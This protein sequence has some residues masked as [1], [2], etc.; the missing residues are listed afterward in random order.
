MPNPRQ[1]AVKALVSVD[2]E[3]GYSNIVLDRLL[4]ESGPS[5]ADSALASAL[6]YGVLDRKVTLD[7]CLQPY[8]SRPLNKLSATVL[9]ALRIAAYQL[10]YMD[11]IPPFAA[12]NESVNLVKRSKDKYAAGLVNAVLRSL[13][14]GGKHTIPTEQTATALSIRCS[15][16]EWLAQRLIDDYGFEIAER[17]LAAGLEP[18][19]TYLR[20]NTLKT[21]ADELIGD[22]LVEGLEAEKVDFVENA[23]KLRK[24]SAENT[25]VFRKGHFHVQDLSSQLCCAALDAR[26][27][28]RVLDVCAAPGGKTFTVAEHMQGKGEVIARDLHPHRAELISKGAERLGLDNVT[29]SVGDATVFDEALGSFDR[30]LCDVVCS[31]I[32]VIRR[33]PEIKYKSAFDADALFETQLKIL[34]TSSRYVARSGLLLYSTCTL[35]KRENHDVLT[36]FLEQN[37]DFS[38]VGEET[39]LMPY[40]NTDGFYFVCLKRK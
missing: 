31:G 27:G 9:N 16:E 35:L 19:A 29:A 12:I 38:V 28:M 30:V 17:I 7:F 14:R 24:S 21:T 5:G 25:E 10:L 33:K 37:D 13:Q 15:C 26:E 20:V 36:A 11:R 22:L 39:T 4:K 34:T 3:G 6:F 32:G 18:S 1:I 8:C 23:V 40:D 2:G